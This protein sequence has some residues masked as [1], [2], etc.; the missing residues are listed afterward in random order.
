[1][2]VRT[3]R[4]IPLVQRHSSVSTMC[5]CGGESHTKK[6]NKRQFTSILETMGPP[7]RLSD[8][9]ESHNVVWD[10]YAALET[11]GLVQSIGDM[12]C[13]VSISRIDALFLL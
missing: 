11:V 6:G 7:R 5:I 3:V 8:R 12:I 2:K 4:T 9:D 13:R 10:T 1:M